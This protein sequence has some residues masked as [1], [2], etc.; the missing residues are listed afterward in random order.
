MPKETF[1]DSATAV[2]N[3]GVSEPVLTITWGAE[4][5]G[6]YINGVEFHA[7][8]LER[9]SGALRRAT[10]KDRTVS[11]KLTADTSEYD[12]AIAAS[13]RRVRELNDELKTAASLTKA[14]HQR[15]SDIPLSARRVVL[16]R[17]GIDIGKVHLPGLILAPEVAIQTGKADVPNKI[18]FSVIA[19]S[20]DVESI[21]EGARITYS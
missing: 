12:A 13:A 6:V 19:D 20:I 10:G 1:W 5:S 2:E 9:L 14:V 3:D 18:T 15:D 7:S 8:A 16:T 17:E 4:K 11:V 21:A